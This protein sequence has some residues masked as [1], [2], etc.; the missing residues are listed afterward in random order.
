MYLTNKSERYNVKNRSWIGCYGLLSTFGPC[1]GE[2]VSSSCVWLEKYILS[3]FNLISEG[4]RRGGGNRRLK[5][6]FPEALM[7]AEEAEAWIGSW[8]S[9]VLLH[10]DRMARTDLGNIKEEVKQGNKVN[11]T[12]SKLPYFKHF[13]DTIITS[14]LIFCDT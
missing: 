12:K 11:E 7:T 1:G 10:W 8:T 3:D 4:D 5:C 9:V 13:K 6:V 14:T 2:L